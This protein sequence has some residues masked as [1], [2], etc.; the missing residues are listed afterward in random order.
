MMTGKNTLHIQHMIK[1][2]NMFDLR[3]NLRENLI[4]NL[5]EH[6][7]NSDDIPLQVLDKLKINI[8]VWV[9]R[10]DVCI[11]CHSNNCDKCIYKDFFKK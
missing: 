5:R 1:T 9:K 3:K 2:E 8:D 7:Y 6:L 11:G 10:E 4:D